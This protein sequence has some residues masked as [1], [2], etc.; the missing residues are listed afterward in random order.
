[1]SNF[2]T[3]TAQKFFED[4][5]LLFWI[6]PTFIILYVLIKIDFIKVTREEWYKKQKAK[7]WFFLSRFILYTLL[8]LTLATPYFPTTLFGK[9]DASLTVLLDNSTSF[10]AF[11]K[12]EV[13]A[14]QER[15]SQNAYIKTTYFGD[16]EKT[17]LGDTIID[18]LVKNGNLLLVT[19]GNNNYGT[20]L[21]DA[22]LQATTLNST[23]HALK[24][25]P[26]IQ[27]TA[28]VIE[29]PD[30]VSPGVETQFTVQLQGTC[31]S[32]CCSLAGRDIQCG[33]SGF[34]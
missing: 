23:I 31:G 33:L 2:I 22:L 30:K 26:I 16:N 4:P 6:I 18:H 12:N 8:I 5:M 9:G 34:C 27:D 28:I 10:T 25:D 1:M 19:D 29:G 14:L 21:R 13:L 11:D 24:L 7:R 15:L 17:P 32:L 3:T 20:Q